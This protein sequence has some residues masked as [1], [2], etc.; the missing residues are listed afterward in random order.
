MVPLELAEERRGAWSHSCRPELQALI[1][2]SSVHHRL[3]ASWGHHCV[4]LAACSCSSPPHELWKTVESLVRWAET[5]H[6]FRVLLLRSMLR[7]N[8]SIALRRWPR[9]GCY[10]FGA[11]RLEANTAGMWPKGA[12][13]ASEWP[14]WEETQTT[15]DWVLWSLPTRFGLDR[16]GTLS[17]AVRIV[18]SVAENIS[19]ATPCVLHRVMF[20]AERWVRDGREPS[21]Q[22]PSL[23]LTNRFL[24]SCW[25]MA[26]YLHGDH[27]QSIAY[28]PGSHFKQHFL[29]FF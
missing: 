12:E 17:D 19:Q 27:L 3:W 29:S 23:T 7:E 1:R 4:W 13:G 16:Q 11:E 8:L 9:E 14:A 5:G 21:A 25:K 18:P 22:G 10:C 20:P 26:I 24:A 6:D 2:M 28:I 15:G